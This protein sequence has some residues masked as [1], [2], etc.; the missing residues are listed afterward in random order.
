MSTNAATAWFFPSLIVSI[1]HC[2]PDCFAYLSLQS[3]YLISHYFY[4]LNF[5]PFGFISIVWDCRGFGLFFVVTRRLFSTSF[6][7]IRL[8]FL[9]GFE[10]FG[11]VFIVWVVMLRFCTLFTNDQSEAGSFCRITQKPIAFQRVGF[12]WWTEGTTV[13]LFLDFIVLLYLNS[14]EFPY[15]IERPFGRF[16]IASFTFHFQFY[17]QSW[18]F[19]P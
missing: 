18:D 14:R 8:G 13:C 9:P 17:R 3:T 12:G 15:F 1:A 16:V 19:T 7:C 2:S 5:V 6:E 11:S 4:G 10:L